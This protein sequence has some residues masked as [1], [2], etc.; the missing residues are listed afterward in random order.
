[1][2]RALFHFP[3][4]QQKTRRSFPFCMT[5]KFLH[6]LFSLILTCH[7]LSNSCHLI[8]LKKGG[9]SF[10]TNEK[11]PL[12]TL[13]ERLNLFFFQ[14]IQA[15]IK[16]SLKSIPRFPYFTSSL[17]DSYRVP[18]AYTSRSFET[19]RCPQPKTAQ[20]KR[21]QKFFRQASGFPRRACRQ[22]T[23]QNRK[24]ALRYCIATTSAFSD[25]LSI[26]QSIVPSKFLSF[27]SR[28]LPVLHSPK[29]VRMQPIKTTE[30][31]FIL[32]GSFWETHR[33][34]L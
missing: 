14:T 4:K 10:R 21:R 13:R 7:S 26:P 8:S 17:F 28:F 19:D 31:R 27:C 18:Y 29:T 15:N 2:S 6:F 33:N 11:K 32:S 23:S 9:E 1:M 16:V 22:E 12:R 5:F 25:C 3:Q 20:I 24:Q 30:A 34:V